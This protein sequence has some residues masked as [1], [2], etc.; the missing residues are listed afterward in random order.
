MFF[1]HIQ[2]IRRAQSLNEYIFLL[3]AGQIHVMVITSYYFQYLFQWHHDKDSRLT[4]YLLIIT[5]LIYITVN[6]I[7]FLILTIT[8]LITT[9]TLL[10]PQQILWFG[11]QI[12]PLLAQEWFPKISWKEEHRAVIVLMEVQLQ[13]ASNQIKVFCVE[14]RARGL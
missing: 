9:F 3:I 8:N 7:E 5:S 11:E 10:L 6:A 12:D 2:K 1:C 4:N 13:Y 14:H